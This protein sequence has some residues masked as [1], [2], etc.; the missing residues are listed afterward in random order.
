[1]KGGEGVSEETRRLVVET[2]KEMGFLPA[3]LKYGLNL[4]R[5]RN[6]LG[7][8]AEELFTGHV[9]WS[10]IIYGIDTAIRKFELNFMLSVIDKKQEQE[11][12]MP[13]ALQEN[14]VDG[15]VV[16]GDSFTEYLKP[17]SEYKLPVVMITANGQK[18]QFDSV[19]SMDAE[20]VASAVRYLIS[21]GH[22]HMVF[23]G[24]HDYAASF[25]NRYLGFIMAMKEAGLLT[26]E[27]IMAVGSLQAR[28]W[29]VDEVD[30]KLNSGQKLP[31]ALVYVNDWLAQGLLQKLYRIGKKV[32]EDISI[33]GFDN[34]A[35]SEECV[36]PLTTLHVYKEYMGEMAVELL[37]RRINNPT[38]PIMNVEVGTGLI[39]RNSTAPPPP[40]VPQ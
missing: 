26:P 18:H 38:I 5:T 25:R 21:L 33:V 2:A 22:R 29:H 19:S 28:Y 9:F 14:N 11:L 39:I 34:I 27:E 40:K 1:L 6:I 31:T 23:V 12:A 7:L 30:Q 35:A 17:L 32:P 10:Q 37:D 3:G 36:P 8:V 4:Y 24:N 15:V 20:G 13:K 16:I